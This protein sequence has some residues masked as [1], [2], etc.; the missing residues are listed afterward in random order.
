MGYN[1]W[2]QKELNMKALMRTRTHTRK[3]KKPDMVIEVSMD[4]GT[5]RESV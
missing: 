4:A 2:D 5:V 3:I 1:S